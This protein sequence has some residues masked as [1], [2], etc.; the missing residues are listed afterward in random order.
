MEAENDAY[1]DPELAAR[2]PHRIPEPCSLPL[3]WNPAL[4]GAYEAST[5]SP[6]QFNG[7]SFAASAVEN[8]DEDA[9]HHLPAL[10]IDVHVV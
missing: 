6:L 5:R 3:S 1:W 7:R 9:F 8:A 2:G 4:R 10:R